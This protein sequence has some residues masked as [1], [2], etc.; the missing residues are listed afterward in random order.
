MNEGRGNPPTLQNSSDFF[1]LSNISASS[2]LISIPPEDVVL[3]SVF[4]IDI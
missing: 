4:I 1:K 2:R 3:F